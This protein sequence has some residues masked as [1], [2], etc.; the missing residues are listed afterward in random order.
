MSR[1]SIVIIGGGPGGYVA[2]IRAA[3]LGYRTAV[4]EREKLGGVCLNRG[5]IP[6]KA[7]LHSAHLLE[8]IKRA[9]EFGIKISD[10][11]VDFSA[12]MARSRNIADEMAKGVDF[13]MNKNKITVIPGNA[14]FLDRYKISVEKDGQKQTVESDRFI[15]A[16][17]ARPRGIPGVSFDGKR[18]ISSREALLLDRAPENFCIIG[19]GA[20]GVEFADFYTSMG[21][22]IT[23]LEYMPQILPQEDTEI[24][25]LLERLLRRRGMDIRTGAK[26]ESAASHGESCDVVWTAVD[27]R[28]ENA[29]F[30]MVL[31]AA[32]IQANT[33]NL[34]LDALGIKLEK[35]K[36][37]VDD[38]C[39]TSA[40]NIYAIGDC[41]PGPALAHAASLEGIHA[42]ESIHAGP[43]FAKSINYELIPACVY[44]HPEIGSV[45]LTES[46]AKAKG[47]NIKTGKFPFS[48]SG[49][50]RAAGDTAGFVKVICE[51][52]TGQILGAHIIGKGASELISEFTVAAVNE[53]IIENIAQTVHAHPTLS[54]SLMEAAASALGQAIHL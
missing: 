46:A 34:N 23:L 11:A 20:I 8:E 30:D 41:T 10:A 37:K 27:G 36:I 54:E 13:L 7:L 33:E 17:G 18:I 25:A 21:S 15:I 48:A 42:V 2:A 38:K 6:T 31:L 1:Y 22:K 51:E 16:A 14:S 49:R 24:S 32:G 35:D 40:G 5:C 9:S 28:K 44:C 53:L 45:G 26:V 12:V 19:A 52:K 39:R 29:K 3:Q 50:A 47:H 4:V 43:S